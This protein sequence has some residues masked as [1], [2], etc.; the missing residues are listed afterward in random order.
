MLIVNGKPLNLEPMP[1]TVQQLLDQLNVSHR[2]LIVER[3]EEIVDAHRYENERLSPGDRIEI[4][5]FVGGG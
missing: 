5:H 4:V 3:N 2:R 1:Q